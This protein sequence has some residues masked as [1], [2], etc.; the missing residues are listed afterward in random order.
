MQYQEGRICSTGLRLCSVRRKCTVSKGLH[1]QQENRVCCCRRKSAVS[2][3]S[4][5]QHAE[6]KC[7]VRK[8]SCA[9]SGERCAV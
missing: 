8:E 2:G 3:I 5:L 4:H 1:L 6:R 9:V 7:A